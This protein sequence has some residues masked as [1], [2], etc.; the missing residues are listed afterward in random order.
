MVDFS[1]LAYKILP[2]AYRSRTRAS[3]PV[4]NDTV[5]RALTKVRKN[6]RE[7]DETCD[8]PAH[9][10]AHYMIA[11]PARRNLKRYKLG[12]IGSGNG[13]QSSLIEEERASLLGI[14]LQRAHGLDWKWTVGF[15]SWNTSDLNKVKKHLLYLY[16]KGL[17]DESGRPTFCLPRKS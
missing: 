11:P 17:I 2:F 7:D 8:D 15:H 9:E 6:W 12:G 13:K 1:D 4:S 5:E 16:K 3:C 10:L 14:L